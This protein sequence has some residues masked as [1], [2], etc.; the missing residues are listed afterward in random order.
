MILLIDNYD[1]FTFNLVQM[2]AGLGADVRV[3]RND[4][5]DAHGLLAHAPAGVVIS[6]GPSHPDRAGNAPAIVRALIELG[7]RDAGRD[8][9]GQPAGALGA[10]P[11][12]GVC[13]GHQVIAR[14]F[15]ARVERAPAPVHGKAATFRHD[16]AGVFAGV[17][18]P[19]TAARYHSLAVVEPTLPGELRVTA[20]T[21]EGVIMGLRHE[22]LPMEGVQ[23]HPESILTPEG[24]TML[25]NFLEGARAY[26]RSRA[27]C[28]EAV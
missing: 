19:A 2:L 26:E 7:T 28:V 24:E 9:G 18:S 5:I 6:P 20:R 8:A 12:L 15:G 11:L 16:G 10:P 14:A 3:F 22:S 25:A 27:A 21:D 13:L 1:S 17:A 4:A 23:F